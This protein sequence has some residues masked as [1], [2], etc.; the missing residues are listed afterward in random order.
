V[1]RRLLDLLVP[2]AC[3]VCRA[4]LRAGDRLCRVC[5]AGLV[6][7]PVDRCRRC[8]LPNPCGLRCPARAAA[9]SQA[10]A[11]VAY[12]GTA[13]ALVRVLKLRGVLAA[14]DV[15]AAQIAAG[16]P[17]AMLADGVLVPVPGHPRRRRARGFDQ[18]ERIATA[19][20]RRAALPVARCLTRGGAAPPQAGAGRGERLRRIGGTIG[21]AGAVPERA[22]L[23]DDV[24]TTG[25]TLDACARAL[26][27]AGS[28]S[29]VAVTY[30]RT[31]G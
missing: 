11:P 24:H 31:L 13:R 23:V 3:I 8:G 22:I 30:A 21:I 19:L 10:W 5:R 12:D 2:P 18:A 4:P 1:F 16:V 28:T 9:F 25:A 6:W 15:M 29:A 7:L 17:P 27:A 14:A 26:R 20:G